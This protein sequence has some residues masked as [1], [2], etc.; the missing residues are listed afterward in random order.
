MRNISTV[1][2]P[3]IGRY[4]TLIPLIKSIHHIDYIS[5]IIIIFDGIPPEEH[6]FD[7]NYYKIFILKLESQRGA[8]TARY[9]A[10]THVTTKY[11][12]FLDD[13]III[14]THWEQAIK[15]AFLSNIKVGTGPVKA[16]D[17]TTMAKSRTIRTA[18]LQGMHLQKIPVLAGGNSFV[19][20]SVLNKLGNFGEIAS[21]TGLAGRLAHMGFD[22]SFFPGMEVFHIH[23]R[24]FFRMMYHGFIVGKS[25]KI[26]QARN[27]IAD[28]FKK[29]ILS[30]NLLIFVINFVWIF[31][32]CCGKFFNVTFSKFVNSK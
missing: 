3:T 17:K 28:I 25:I 12:I 1:I 26:S 13:D 20:L 23:D 9:L 30:R 27:L 8:T 15:N 2:I 32:F 31:S 11:V 18:I 19:L 10:T 22:I 14:G 21:F 7:E 29:S 6:I 4:E 16:I 5:K 24:G